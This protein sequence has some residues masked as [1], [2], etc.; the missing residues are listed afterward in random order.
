MIVHNDPKSTATFYVHASYPT[1][2]VVTMRYATLADA[3]ECVRE[4]KREGGTARIQVD[5]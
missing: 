4:V 3:M 5:P 2:P 1:G